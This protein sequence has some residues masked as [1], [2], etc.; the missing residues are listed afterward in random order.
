RGRA[1][2]LPLLLERGPDPRG[3]AELV[4][5]DPRRTRSE[6]L[7]TWMI[8]NEVR[9]LDRV[10][11]I[12]AGARTIAVLGASIHL[13]R[14]AHYVPEYLHAR[15]YRIIPVNPLHAREGAVGWGE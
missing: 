1:P 12:L 13:E 2:D 15:G 10:R 14:P 5:L 6:P 11:E 9:S 4:R 7:G 8:V 3:H